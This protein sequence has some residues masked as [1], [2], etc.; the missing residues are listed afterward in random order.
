VPN[1]PLQY[2]H[3]VKLVIDV[4]IEFFGS[5][6]PSEPLQYLLLW[7]VVKL[8]TEVLFPKFEILLMTSF[9]FTGKVKRLKAIIH[10]IRFVLLFDLSL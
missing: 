2:L 5:A 9:I 4:Y 7:S 8:V 6:M 1:E 3:V 10:F